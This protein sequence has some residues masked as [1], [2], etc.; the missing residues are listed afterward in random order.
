MSQQPVTQPYPPVS[1]SRLWCL[2]TLLAV[3][4]YC[5]SK[6]LG[7]S[8]DAVDKGLQRM[9]AHPESQGN[10]LINS[11]LLITKRS[12]LC[13]LIPCLLP[14]QPE[15]W[16]LFRLLNQTHFYLVERTEKP[17]DWFS[18]LNLVLNTREIVALS[19]PISGII[20]SSLSIGTS[21]FSQGCY[22]LRLNQDSLKCFIP[23]GFVA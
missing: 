19:V 2:A 7:S 23:I 18:H 22:K 14:H 4:F 16:T 3:S 5:S 20:W 1:I 10:Q 8:N 6:H 21:N 15:L 13:E 11:Y 9:R 17:P 12:A